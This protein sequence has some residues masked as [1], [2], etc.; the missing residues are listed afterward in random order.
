MVMILKY[1]AA[2]VDLNYKHPTSVYSIKYLLN[3]IFCRGLLLSCL[4]YLMDP[5]ITMDELIY[6]QCIIMGYIDL[7][8]CLVT[9]LIQ[10]CV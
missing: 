2:L 7:E 8:F 9:L 1:N 4:F 5:L 3:Y 6:V 10:L